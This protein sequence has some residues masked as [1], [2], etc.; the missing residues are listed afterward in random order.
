MQDIKIHACTLST[1]VGGLNH[2]FP[3]HP[4]ASADPLNAV[5]RN[6]SVLNYS[7]STTT[8]GC[9]F[10]NNQSFY[11]M[12]CCSTDPSVPPDTSVHNISSTRGTEVTVDLGGLTSDQMYYC[13][14]AA[15][16]IDNSTNCHDPVVGGVKMFFSTIINSPLV[17]TDLGMCIGIYSHIL[18]I[19]GMILNKKLS[20]CGCLI[21]GINRTFKDTD[22]AP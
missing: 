5:V 8:I 14:A 19:Y 6:A 10:L 4:S 11:C 9:S 18:Y 21:N 22:S 20:I 2:S 13:K 17:A 7:N 12:V 1:Y 15:T 16:N 3:L